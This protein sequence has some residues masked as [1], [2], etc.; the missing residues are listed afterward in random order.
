M[1]LSD[2]LA[3][4]PG[5]IIFAMAVATI[6]TGFPSWWEPM[7]NKHLKVSAIPFSIVCT[8]SVQANSPTQ[9]V[10]LWW[11]FHIIVAGISSLVTLYLAI[12]LRDDYHTNSTQRAKLSSLHIGIAALQLL[13]CLFAY[14][15][16]QHAT[17]VSHGP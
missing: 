4:F 14:R 17:Q 1:D 6:G 5:W 7:T 10:V 15:T 2:V 8:R 16:R 13:G 12:F 9:R 3:Q 11:Q